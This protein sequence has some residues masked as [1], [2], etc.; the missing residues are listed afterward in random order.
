M[1]QRVSL[2]AAAA[3]GT[4]SFTKSKV[5]C[6]DDHVPAIEYEF[7][8]KGGLS[9]YDAMS[10]RRGFQVYRQVCASC[11]SMN[12]IAFRNMVGVSHTEEQMKAIAES[13]EVMDGP[14]DEGEMFERPGKL[15]DSFPSPYG[16]EEQARASNAG[17]LPPDL[18][19]LVKAR[20]DGPNYIFAL[21]TGYVDTPAGKQLPAGLHYNPYFS[22]GAIAMAKQLTDGQVEYED[23]TPAT[24]AQMAKDIAVFLAWASEPEADD[25]KKAGM[26]MLIGVL[27][28]VAVTAVYKRFRWSVFKTQKH[29]WV[30]K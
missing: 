13:Y 19:C 9:S 11:H 29:S 30:K 26:K 15:S 17:A 21:L 23:G 22:G 3:V 12:K 16:N 14:N 1:F 5:Q 20:H 7:P 4:I 27:C 25:R 8:M 24:E 18:S 10:I 6:S 28:A 2:T